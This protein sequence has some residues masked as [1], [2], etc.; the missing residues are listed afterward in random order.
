M[1]TRQ[2]RLVIKNNTVPS[3]PFSGATLLKGE[4]IVNTADGIL[5][6]SGVTSSSANW[7]PAGPGGNATFFEVGSNLYDL[8]IRNQITAYSGVTNLS[9][10]FL[11][12]TTNGFVLADISDIAGVDS[13]TT[14]A[15]W[16]PNVLTLKLNNGKPNVSVTIN[17]FTALTV[18]NLTVTGT[19]ALSGSA[20]Y[21]GTVSG[22]NPNELINLDYLTGFSQTNDV[23]VTGST[24]T[25]A[26]N[27][28][29]SQTSTLLYHGVPL[30]GGYT[31]VTDNT[32]TTG[33]TYDNNTTLITFDKNDG[34]SY[35]VSLSGID[36]NDTYVTGGTVTSGGTLNLVRNDSVTVSIPK[37]T[38]WT[39]GSTG[40]FAIKAI[41]KC[42]KPWCDTLLYQ[43]ID[44]TIFGPKAKM[45][46]NAA[47]K[48]CRAYTFEMNNM[49]DTC[50]EYYYELW[51][52][53]EW[54]NKM[55]NKEWNSLTDSAIYFGYSWDEKNI[56]YYSTKSER[57]LKHEFS[58]SGRYIVYSYW[59][60]K[61]SGIDT[62][63]FTKITV[64]PTEP[65]TSVKSLVKNTE[66]KIVGYYDIM[67]RQ[68]DY[69]RPNEVY[70]I[71]YNNG[72]RRK[73]MQVQN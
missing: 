17:A 57:V 38:Y 53:D 33:G 49:N 7:T 18:G 42:T 36:V 11:S 72:Q 35:S 39:S 40:S 69:M 34:T 12:G 70:I 37:V 44:I 56:E 29:D 47:P 9:G 62:W 16:N 73:V 63:S 1:A 48:N 65:T 45:S 64:C 21:Y 15:T 43:Y 10:K 4:A 30:G 67:G 19:T 55:S 3:A 71:L 58:D 6:F 5:M 24:L 23:Y 31:I 22:T 52:A 61:C 50:M 32:F 28:N 60:N 20:Y 13:Y 41:N 27:N 26:T 14:G 68:V 2:T 51:K 8:K 25:P 59:Y 46:Y 54:I 66:L